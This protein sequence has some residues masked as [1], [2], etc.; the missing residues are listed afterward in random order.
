MFEHLLPRYGLPADTP[1]RLLNRSE[2]AT[3]IA[4][5]ALILRVHR[6]GYHTDAEIASELAWLTALQSVSSLRCV[7]PVADTTGTLLQHASAQT[8]VAFAPI[9]GREV[10]AED[11]LP[12]WFT[13]L[14]EISAH[15]HAHA[16]Q[17]Q[18]PAGFTRKRWDC[19]TILGDAP[20]WG[21]WQ[22]APGLAPDGARILTRLSKALCAR[23]AVYG[24]GP[25]RFGLIHADLRLTNLMVDDA[26]LW[27]IDF[28]DCGFGWWMY[29]LAAALSFIEDDPRLPAVIAAWCDGYIRAGTLTPEDRAIIPTLIMLRR[30]LLT[31]W[32]GSRSDSDTVQALDGQGYAQGTVALAER[33]FAV[34]PD[35]IW[36]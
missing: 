13:H 5:D 25:D 24:M 35:R 10:A 32:V 1:I 23:L 16:R 20:H 11:D 14:G 28:D 26:G 6:Q 18:P 7:Q 21:R 3:Y 33:Y 30:V 27:V 17:W 36:A 31:A 9:A 34:G 15:L 19:E 12:H 2:N 29:D 22:D 8:I 4:G